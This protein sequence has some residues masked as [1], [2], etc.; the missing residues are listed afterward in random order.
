MKRKKSFLII[1]SLFLT[2]AFT[3]KADGYIVKN[4]LDVGIAFDIVDMDNDFTGNTA[5]FFLSEDN[6]TVVWNEP[7]TEPV[8]VVL[9]ADEDIN[10][11]C[12]LVQSNTA[13][14]KL[15]KNR[16]KVYPIDVDKLPV[17]LRLGLKY[18][19]DV[20]MGFIMKDGSTRVYML[21]S[22]E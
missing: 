6:A 19:G 7:D 12:A 14:T 9:V 21:Y 18:S 15:N 5:Y 1:L 8:W 10:Y 11:R 17:E 4:I 3:A 13:T 16:S 22:E 20:G 2:L